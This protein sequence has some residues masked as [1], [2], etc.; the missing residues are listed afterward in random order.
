[1]ENF[2]CCYLLCEITLATLL[3]FYMDIC[4]SFLGV[5]LSFSKVDAP[6]LLQL[7]NRKT[8]WH[9]Q[10]SAWAS[11]SILWCYSSWKENF[12]ETRDWENG[13][14]FYWSAQSVGPQHSGVF[15]LAFWP[16]KKM[17]S[18][19]LV[20]E[21]FGIVLLVIFLDSILRKCI[22]FHLFYGFISLRDR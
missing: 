17:V 12:I 8:V 3:L 14:V 7:T 1:M 10:W 21:T 16:M 19:T 18:L 2:L 15:L 20:A 5:F 4:Y 11:N 9:F 22:L 6:S 13:A